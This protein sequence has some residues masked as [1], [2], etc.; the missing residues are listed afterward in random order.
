MTWPSRSHR[1][2]TAIRLAVRK[3]KGLQLLFGT[4]HVLTPGMTF[5]LYPV[6]V[7]LQMSTMVHAIPINAYM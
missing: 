1:H 6:N 4:E 5:V 3:E 2:H 7:R